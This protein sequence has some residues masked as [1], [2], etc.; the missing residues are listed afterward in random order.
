MK[1]SS[2]NQPAEVMP[3][4]TT[5]GDL[6]FRLVCA[7]L[8][9]GIIDGLFSSV[10][11]VAAYQSTVAR[12]FQGVAATVLG[13]QAFNGGAS[14]VAIGMLMHFGVALLW[15]GI[16][17][18]L[19]FRWHW[20]RAV[21][22]SRYGIIKFALLYGPFV[23]MMMSLVVIPV[24]TRRAPAITIRWWVQL[25]GHFPFVGLPIVACSLKAR[26]R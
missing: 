22:S 4:P 19:L 16:F 25:L 23:W 2:A 6:G 8:L 24:L 18:F 13:T 5:L 17:L 21:L 12:L 14:T 11:S 20:V 10:L 26:L 1:A 7:T 3:Y 15:S 9:T